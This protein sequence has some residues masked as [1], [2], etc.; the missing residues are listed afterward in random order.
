MPGVEVIHIMLNHVSPV[1]QNDMKMNKMRISGTES[2][3]GPPISPVITVQSSSHDRIP[4]S[5]FGH[6]NA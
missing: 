6:E 4:I 2:K 5:A 3:L 1:S